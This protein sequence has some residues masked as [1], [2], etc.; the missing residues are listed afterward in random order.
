MLFS[1][2]RIQWVAQL[3]FP[4]L[5]IAHSGVPG[6]KLRAMTTVTDDNQRNTVA[7]D[8]Y[9]YSY[10]TRDRVVPQLTAVVDGSVLLPCNLSV[11]PS[12]HDRDNVT[13]VLWSKSDVHGP[14]YSVDARNA[15]LERARHFPSPDTGGRYEFNTSSQPA[16][17]RIDPV[18]AEDAGEFKCRVDFRWARTQ[19][20]V[21]MLQVIVPPKQT[22]IMDEAGKPLQD[23]IG[24]YDEGAPLKLICEADGGYPLPVVTWWR[25]TTLIDDTYHNT[26]EGSSRNEVII[27]HLERTDA[28]A[29][30]TCQAANTNL[31]LAAFSSIVLDMNLKPLEAK[32]T[33]IP[34]PLPE[35]HRVELTCHSRGSQPPARVTWWKGNEQL[36]RTV[37]KMDAFGNASS[38]TLIFVP[39]A[40][41]DEKLLTCKADNPQLPDSTVEDSI[42]LSVTYVPKLSLSVTSLHKNG[43]ILEGTDVLLECTVQANPTVREVWWKHNGRLLDPSQESS[44]DVIF[45]N[46]SLKLLRIKRSQAGVYQCLASNTQGQGESNELQLRI[47]F[48]PVC[49]E[50]QKT[51]YGVARDEAARVSCELEA[52]PPDV[53]FQ[54]RF[55]NTFEERHLTA[56]SVDQGLRSVASYIPRTRNDYG[57][58]YCWGKNNVG[59]QV[60]PCVFTIMAAGPPEPLS[61]CNVVNATEDSLKVECDPGYDGGL[62]QTFHLEVIDSLSSETMVSQMQKDRPTFFVRSL[63]PGTEYILRVFSQNAKGRSDSDVFTAATA[64]ARSNSDGDLIGLAMSPLLGVLIG[65]VGALILVAIIIAIIMRMRTGDHD[66][67]SQQPSPT[68]KSQTLLRK[69]MTEDTSEGDIKDP[70]IIPPKT[71]FED[72]PGTDPEWVFRQLNGSN[73]GRICPDAGGTKGGMMYGTLPN[74]KVQIPQQFRDDTMY[75]ERY[76]LGTSREFDSPVGR[77]RGS[78]RPPGTM[79]DPDELDRM[80]SSNTPLVN[81]GPM[82]RRS[83]QI[84]DTPERERRAISTPV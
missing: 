33:N 26:S 23:L 4:L 21:I 31:T 52:D 83:P 41:D 71:D 80:I 14:V 79:P 6:I 8:V 7:V 20:Y 57:T 16:Y 36:I 9:D 64:E 66:T 84:R 69:G 29:V 15:P 68:E 40:E 67:G 77:Y 58:L 39:S 74:V 70:D 46:Q 51:I 45:G 42:F 43:A 1:W 65:G 27:P 75:R 3:F 17:L 30:F 34:G 59:T 54:W 81:N 47:R 24:P 37:D 25:E 10:A 60:K 73:G 19:T 5:H 11:P 82:L 63:P 2:L 78:F 53:H 56:L 48:T 44:L 50:G 13:L 62:E 55:N 72:L 38:S 61:N 28:R 76:P 35:G 49:R 22:I 12:N 32:I 18:H